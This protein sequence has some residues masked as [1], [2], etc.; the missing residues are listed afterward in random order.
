MSWFLAAFGCIWSR[1]KALLLWPA[2]CYSNRMIR[3]TSIAKS[4]LMLLIVLRFPAMV[5]AASLEPTTSK[6]WEEY[7]ASANM[8]MEQRLRPG[9]TF[10]WVD[11]KPQRLANVRAGEIVVSPVGPRSPKKVPSGLIHDWVGDVFIPDATVRGVLEVVRD[12]ARFKDLYQP[13]VI[14]SKVIAAGEARDRYSMLLI[15]KS[16]FLKTALD[17]DYE[18]SFVHVDERRVYS[19]SRSTRI[20]E[21]ERYGAPAQRTLNEDESRGILWRLFSITRY[22]ERDGGVYLE[23]EAIG[24]SRDIPSSLRWLVEPIVR[25]VSRSSLATCLQQTEDAVRVRAEL[26]N[27]KPGSARSIAATARERKATRNLQANHSFR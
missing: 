24:L 13:S 20:Q 10:L 17:T 26:A 19:V 9:H 22:V 23:L 15:N 3:M 6:A 2:N 8:G 27:G 11:E 12:Y 5:D 1:L 4:L 16:F 7:V 21:I 14:D 18:S 25:R